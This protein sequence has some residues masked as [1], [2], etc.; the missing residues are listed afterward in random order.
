MQQKKKYI[1]Y[2]A[3]LLFVIMVG[4]ASV[5]VYNNKHNHDGSSFD[6]FGL[7]N[8]KGKSSKLKN[9]SY[10]TQSAKQTAQYTTK[11]VNKQIVTPENTQRQI[12][13]DFYNSY[14]SNKNVGKSQDETLA[15]YGTANLATQF[16]NSKPGYDVLTCGGD[17]A[18]SAAISGVVS[19]DSNIGFKLEFS[20]AEKVVSS[21]Q[22]MFS[23]QG[24]SS[25][26]DSVGCLGPV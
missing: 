1:I 11:P 18:I 8:N 15:K 5:A 25:L 17:G 22:V 3:S 12:V 7:I 14:L 2:T 9:T 20:D 24:A 26:V 6:V 4:S 16:K 13:L 19:L 23:G 10:A 21:A